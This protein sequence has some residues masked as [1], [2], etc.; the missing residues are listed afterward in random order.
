MKKKSYTSF[1]KLILA[2]EKSKPIYSFSKAERF[3]SAGGVN[4]AIPK[5]TPG[6]KYD[7]PEVTRYKFDNS[8]KWR[9]G[10]AKRRPIYDRELF[11]QKSYLTSNNQRGGRK[12]TKFTKVVGGA[13]G[14]EQRIKREFREKTPGPGNYTPSLKCTRPKSANYFIG[15]KSGPSSLQLFTG[16][17]NDVGPGKYRPESAVYHSHHTKFPVYSIGT[18]KRPP[19]STPPCSE[20]TKFMN[21]SSMQKQVQSQKRTE[22]MISIGKSTRETEKKRGMFN[23]MMERQPVKFCIPMPKF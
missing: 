21:Y 18:G 7:V 2:K 9:I 20:N 14:N 23:C 13:I 5:Y 6:P 3:A 16:T 19:L 4:S 10:T 8:N 17:N 12:P 22:D 11:D 1:G 15:E